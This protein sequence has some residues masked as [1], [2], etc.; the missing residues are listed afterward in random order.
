MKQHIQKTN[1]K[2]IYLHLTCNNFKKQTKPFIKTVQIPNSAIHSL[3]WAD[4]VMHQAYQ[5]VSFSCKS[6]NRVS[7]SQKK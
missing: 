1:K 4:L 3:T 7:E 6:Y 5:Q 2:S